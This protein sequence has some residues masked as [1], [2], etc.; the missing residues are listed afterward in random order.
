MEEFL[1]GALLVG[2]SLILFF[3]IYGILV[4]IWWKRAI[5]K[6][7]SFTDIENACIVA[8]LEEQR[9]YEWSEDHGSGRNR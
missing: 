6:G 2:G 1:A 9:R 5:P 8:H 3:G 7:M 4:F